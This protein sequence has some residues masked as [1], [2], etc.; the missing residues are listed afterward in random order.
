MWKNRLKIIL[1]SSNFPATSN[2]KHKTSLSV[3]DLQD[4]IRNEAIP[5]TKQDNDDTVTSGTY[6]NY[7]RCI[8]WIVFG[9]GGIVL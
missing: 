5:I 1:D 8:I 2:E 4:I 9:D 3:S 6:F 7:L